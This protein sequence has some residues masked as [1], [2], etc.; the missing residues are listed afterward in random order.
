VRSTQTWFSSPQYWQTQFRT[1]SV[2][3]VSPYN[4]LTPIETKIILN[5]NAILKRKKSG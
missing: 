5:P 4:L 3:M 1:S 2:C